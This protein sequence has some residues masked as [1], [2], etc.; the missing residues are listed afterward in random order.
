MPPRL[1][2]PVQPCLHS[3]HQHNRKEPHMNTANHI[4][5]N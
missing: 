4:V 2:T 1:D 5:N 3:S